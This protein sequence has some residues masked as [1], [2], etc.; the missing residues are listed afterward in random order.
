M[1]APWTWPRTNC[2]P[3]FLNKT[4]ETSDLADV[5]VAFIQ[6]LVN[7]IP[8]GAWYY[9]LAG[10]ALDLPGSSLRRFWEIHTGYPMF[11]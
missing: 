11:G 5:E 3:C 10:L 2:N 9:L 7:T 8:I 1:H 6:D 4:Q